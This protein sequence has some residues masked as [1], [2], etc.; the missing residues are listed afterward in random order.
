MSAPAKSSPAVR[1][2]RKPLE[3]SNFFLYV[4]GPRDEDI[5]RIWARRISRPLARCLESRVVIL[6]GR[7]PARA[8]EHFRA[9]GGGKR[10]GRGLVVLD[11]D[12]HAPAEHFSSF[13]SGLEVFT[14]KR[15]H[16]ESYLMVPA[17]IRRSL[18]S[19]V[20]P[21]L[22]DQLIEDHVPSPGDETACRMANAKKILGAK[23]ELGRCAG[24]RLS[25]ARVARCM[26]IDE[27][28]PDILAL[29]ARIQSAVG[30]PGPPSVSRVGR[31][32]AESESS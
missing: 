25:P 21:R 16:I 9:E 12:H 23:G 6:G 1:G 31:H 2:P 8:R 32:L 24:G 30:I 27:F 13:E 7:R 18:E 4:E 28:H 14:W 5:L 11:R 29:Y 22:L 15:R 26:R 20:A 17:A 3:D 19:V 10:P